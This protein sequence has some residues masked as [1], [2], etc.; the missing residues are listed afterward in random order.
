LFPGG[1]GDFG[2]FREKK[3][4]VSDWTRNML[5]YRDG[6]FAKDRIWCFFALDFATRKKNQMQG[7]FFV[8]GF[9]KEGPKNLD[10]LKAEIENGN[11]AW[12]DHLCYYSSQVAGSPGYW[13]AKR[14]E[15]YTW[16]N[17][18]IEAEH[19]P[20]NFFITLS[21]AEYLW[22]DIRRLISDRFTAA[23]LDAP[24]LET[25]FVQLVNDYTL[26]VQE[27]FQE[28]VKIWLS[29]IGAKVFH[30]KYYWLRY[31]FAPSRGQIHAHILAIHD[32]P[33][34][35]E[36]YYTNL[37]NKKKQEE[38]LYKW[39]TEELGM[40]AS[41]PENSPISDKDTHPSKLSYKEVSKTSDKDFL[42]CLQ[43]LQYHKCSAFCMRKQHVL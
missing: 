21:C 26:I 24:D 33:V 15:V 3:L 34:V 23:G 9:F 40:K 20:P 41:F 29:T 5:Y 1:Y 27:Y 4:N 14:A 39:M 31:E 11:T 18:H 12:I 10:Q 37:G 8:D 16:I 35:M 7:G 28:Q 25:S 32:N 22:Q 2:Q 36:P 43:K 42:C 13:R 6:R 19:G 38:F 30:I 17:H